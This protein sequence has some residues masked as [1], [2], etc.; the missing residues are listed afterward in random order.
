MGRIRFVFGTAAELIKIYPLIALAEAQG[1]D[2]FA[3]STGQSGHSVRM[4]WADFKLPHEKLGFILDS[5]KDLEKSWQAF[6]WF[7]KAST[8]TRSWLRMK[9]FEVS[10]W[11]LTPRD[12]FLIHGDTLSTLVGAFWAKR[13]GVFSG[14][15]EAGLRSPKL[16]H[17]FPEEIT[18][19]WVSQLAHA[20]FPPDSVAAENLARS[21]VKGKVVMTQA[22][23]LLDAVRTIAEKFLPQKKPEPY[24]VVN[25]HRYEN[26]HSSERWKKM[27]DVVCRAAEKRK[28]YFVMHA[29]TQAKLESDPESKSRLINQKVELSP[30]MPFCEF[31]PLLS[32]SDFVISDGGSNQEECFYLGKPCLLLRDATERRE[33]LGENNLL[34]KF[35]DEEINRF[36]ESP[37]SFR[38]SP[39]SMAVHPSQIILD[40]IR[41]ERHL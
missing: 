17:P 4:Q 14:H 29:P 39:V 26:L 38:R 18:R 12:W 13:L 27:I 25:L 1:K 30:R 20:H 31:I 8:L 40:A 24:V 2:W 6:Q 22:N 35:K 5:H 33:G 19:R 11:E 41:P 36:L 16:F 21:R 15:I 37:D 34:S 9:V 28:V 32:G 10:G 23:T 3:L 7:F